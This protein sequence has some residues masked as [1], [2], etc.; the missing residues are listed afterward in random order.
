MQT[1]LQVK[2]EAA[3]ELSKDLGDPMQFIYCC[4]KLKKR[5][6]AAICFKVRGK[7]FEW[8]GKHIK[9][10]IS[11]ER[12]RQMVCK[13]VEVVENELNDKHIPYKAL[14]KD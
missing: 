6:W 12:V 8:T 2:L 5:N 9:P 1:E 3:W 10:Q 14:I 4:E 7:T 13:F 11:K